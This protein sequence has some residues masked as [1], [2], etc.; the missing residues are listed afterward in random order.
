LRSGDTIAD[1][2]VVVRPLGK[3][4]LASTFLVRDRAYD[5]EVALKLVAADAGSSEILK[6]EFLALRSCSHPRLVRVHDFG[7]WRHRGAT[8]AFYTSILVEGAD[9]QMVAKTGSWDDLARPIGDVLS[10]IGSLHR[11]G[12]LHGDVHPGNVL[13]DASSR[14]VLIDLS[15]VR[16]LS[17]ERATEVSGTAGFVAPELLR[18]IVDRTADLFALGMTIR[19]LGVPLPARVERALSRLVAERPE[20]RPRSAEEA[21]AALDVPWTAPAASDLL[22]GTLVGRDDALARLREALDG[23]VRGR[24]APRTIALAGADGVGRTRLLDELKAE[25]QQRTRTVL[26]RGGRGALLSLLEIASGARLD[27]LTTSAALGALDRIA[28]RREPV[29]LLVDDAEALPSDELEL[30]RALVRSTPGGGSIAFVVVANGALAASAE[31]TIALEPLEAH[32]VRAWLRAS[33]PDSALDEILRATGGYPK[34]IA[35]L[36]GQ[37]DDGAWGSRTLAR[38]VANAATARGELRLDD[39]DGEA[40]ALLAKIVAAGTLAGAGGPALET[41]VRRGLVSVDPA[42]ARLLRRS[43]AARAAAALGAAAMRAAHQELAAAAEAELAAA[44]ER[45]DWLAALVVHLV[46][47]DPDEAARRLATATGRSAVAL[48]PAADAVVGAHDRASPDV[49]LRCAEIYAEAGEPARALGLV[50]RAL[51][52]RPARET[53]SALRRLAGQC[54]A[55]MGDSRRAVSVL[56]RLLPGVTGGSDHARVAAALSLALLK[57]G[58]DTEAIEVVRDALEGAEAEP[59]V[60]LDLLLNGAFAKS[61]SGLIAEARADL[62]RAREIADSASPRGRFRL[63]SA[64]GFVEYTAGETRAAVRAY[65]VALDLAEQSGL[66]DLVASAALNYGSACHELGDLGRALE[67]YAR[68]HRLAVALGMPTTVATLEFDRAKVHADIGSWD[69]A[70]RHAHAATTAA[71]RE[72]MTLIEAGAAAVLAEVASARGE[73]DEA[74]RRLDEAERLVAGASEREILALAVQRAK[75]RIAAGDLAL[76]AEGL[77][78]CEATMR[79]SGARDAEAAWLGARAAIALAEGRPADA[80]LDLER[81]IELA[82]ASGQRGLVADLEARLADAFLVA[83]SPFLADR[84]RAR[85]REL[86]ERT[87]ASLPPDLHDAFRRHPARA[88]VFAAPEVPPRDVVPADTRRFF[89]INRRL[90]SAASTNAVLEETMDAAISLTNA[91]RGF[92]LVDVGGSLKVAVARNV[93]RETIRQG[94]LKL[95]HTVAERVVRT[96]EPVITVDAA[97]DPRFARSRSVHAMR[98]KSLLC[99][100]IRSPDGILGAIYVDHRFSSGTFRAE[101]VDVLL[102]L[103]DQAALALVKARLVEELRR[104]T[105]ELEERNAEIERLAR[106]QALEIARLKQAIDD[107]RRGPDPAR[108]FDYGDLVARSAAMRRVLSILDRVID[109]DITVLV[110]GESGTGKERIARA[111]HANSARRGGPFVAINCGALPEALLEA[112]LFGYRRGAFSGAIRDRPGLFVA[113]NGGTLLLDELGE[114]S[115]SMQVKLLR[116][117]QEREVRPLGAADAVAVDVRV[118]CATNRNLLEQVRAGRFREDLYYRVA[119]VDVELPPLRSR[120]EDVLPLAEQVLARLATELGRPAARLDRS[121]E[122]ALLAHDWPGNVR[123]L[124]NV[125]TKAFLLGKSGVL[126]AEDLELGTSVPPVRHPSVALRARILATLEETDWNVVSAS[127]LLGIPRPTL[128]RKMRA[129]GIERPARARA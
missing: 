110:R 83:G 35:A 87:L 50:A 40:R 96:G 13:V 42:G 116:A 100:P 16:P 17:E 27:A 28:A 20:D 10:A 8:R 60:R 76:A 23:L 127:R 124:E 65:A 79:A 67:A 14:G 91:E 81:A 108:R 89:E 101:L 41:L 111:I 56:R 78:A 84:H 85:A 97:F 128:Y 102:A 4:G 95:S 7:Y 38:A 114:M 45:D 107:E 125:L 88:A 34:E 3:G 33:I 118:V 19:A 94:H 86:W 24:D 22:G 62:V 59:N 32:H 117:L 115:P 18:G 121:A 9:L 113:A 1:R 71:R 53:Q 74:E 98:L 46:T 26:V 30:L 2:Y 119:V 73:H 54:Y 36:L 109:T 105:R 106:G 63:A 120:L 104:K 66:D 126:R 112:E 64:T 103:G 122:R 93:D 49:L 21:A 48:R 31:L 15:C 29:L 75:A 25:A 37:L 61:R 52:R 12:L 5:A 129:L 90:N 43:D 68:G 57:R 58:A 82:E 51:R 47:V 70:M 11:R 123:E 39:L 6:R 92:L 72:Q 69:L 77:R 99:V 80:S 44:P 55:Q